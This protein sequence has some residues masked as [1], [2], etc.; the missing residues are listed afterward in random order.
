MLIGP[1][2]NNLNNLI[3]HISQ[4]ILELRDQLSREKLNFK[5]I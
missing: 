3:A 1:Y 5:N 2:Y 4:N